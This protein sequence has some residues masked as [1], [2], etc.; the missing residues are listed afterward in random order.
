MATN[1]LKGSNVNNVLEAAAKCLD[2]GVNFDA[3]HHWS[4]LV[5]LPLE[6]SNDLKCNAPP[7]NVT[8]SGLEPHVPSA[9]AKANGLYAC[10]VDYSGRLG[11]LQECIGHAYGAAGFPLNWYKFGSE[12]T[13][14]RE[15]RVAFSKFRIT[16]AR[17]PTGRSPTGK[18]VIPSIKQPRKFRQTPM[19]RIDARGLI[20]QYKDKIW[21][22][23][24][25]LD[26][27]SICEMGV[28]T[29]INRVGGGIDSEIELHEVFTIPLP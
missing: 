29:Q 13:R 21:V 4:S 28:N 9:E 14:R 16:L 26:R 12:I 6:S 19:P 27:L 3:E 7:L 5:H 17:S 24:V 1:V 25:R 22:E 2:R 20:E 15:E 23:N 11:R 8:I 18:T 10:V